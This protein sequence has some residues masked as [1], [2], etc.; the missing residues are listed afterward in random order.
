MTTHAGT[1]SHLLRAIA[2]HPDEDQPR[3]EFADWLDEQEPVRAKC[4][5]CEGEKVAFAPLGLFEVDKSGWIACPTCHGSG[6]VTDDTDRK[7]AELIRVQYELERGYK[8]LG[9][10]PLADTPE[11]YPL[12]ERNEELL[13]T[14]GPVL[15]R[16]A[17]CGKCDGGWTSTPP[18]TT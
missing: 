13:R 6:T 9:L 12:E 2:A 4:P 11:F 16:G 17:K 7:W 3:L 8:R 10:D 5:R 1:R 18:F 14:L 15:R